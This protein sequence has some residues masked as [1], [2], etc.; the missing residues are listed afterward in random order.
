MQHQ[1][2]FQC[3]FFTGTTVGDGN[4]DI[5]KKLSI[6]SL[7]LNNTYY[8]II[9]DNEGRIT[10]CSCDYMYI[11]LAVCEYMFFWH[12]EYLVIRSILIPKIIWESCRVMGQISNNTRIRVG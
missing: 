2:I 9:L 8:E 11:N 7:S 10:K 5:D 6:K 3:I 12:Q 1:S 4:D